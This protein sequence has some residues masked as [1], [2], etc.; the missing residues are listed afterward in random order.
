M[1]EWLLQIS[2][3]NGFF[4]FYFS[5]WYEQYIDKHFILC[6]AGSIP[7]CVSSNI[8]SDSCSLGFC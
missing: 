4:I 5:F 3:D 2:N 6:S 7:D 1:L 8:R